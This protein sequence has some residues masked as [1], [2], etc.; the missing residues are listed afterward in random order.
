MDN[1][2]NLETIEL[3]SLLT[4]IDSQSNL[5]DYLS[6]TLN[7]PK[8]ILLHEYFSRTFKEKGLSKSTVIKNSD[9]D[10]TYAYEILRGNK[11]PSRDKILQLCIG[12]SFNL[13]ESNKA[14][15]IGNTGELYAKVPRDSIIIFGINNNLTII[16][17]NELLFSYKLAL[18]G[19]E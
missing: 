16:E 11:K 2:N 1:V 3:M 14:L 12:A 6:N 4:N 13:E 15:K 5:E 17:I 8:N 18:L 10:R 9:L 19:E 7:N